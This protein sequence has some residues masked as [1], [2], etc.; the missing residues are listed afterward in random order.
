LVDTWEQP[1]P[2][3]K[4]DDEQE[5]YYSGKQKRHTRKNQMISLPKGIDI[6]DVVIGEKGPRNDGKLLEQTQAELPFE[7][8]FMGDK[9]YVG[10][11]NTTTPHKK[12]KDSQLNQAQKDFNK[13]VSQKRVYV[14]HVIRVIKVWRIA[15]EEFRMGSPSRAASL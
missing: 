15:K 13:Q 10:R 6:V 11:K 12:P 2:R 8:R 4:D 14:E 7:L 1:I 3:P 5:K 9:A